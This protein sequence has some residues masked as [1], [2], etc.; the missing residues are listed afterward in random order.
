LR[1]K[2][3][4]T[5]NVGAGL[6]KGQGMWAW[7]LF[8]ASGLLLVVYLFAHIFV[9][10]MSHFGGAGTA[11]S[12]LYNRLMKF[13][14]SPAAVV[15]DLCLVGVVLYHALNGV[16]IILMDFGVGIKQHKVIFW[17]CMAVTAACVAVFAYVAFF[18]L[19]KEVG[20]WSYVSGVAS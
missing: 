6:W 17:I 4:E 19:A 11:D 18:Y 13:F 15:L 14:D 5:A 10:S 16:R 3:R 2:P 12:N 9:T 8:R 1:G 20:P 7:L